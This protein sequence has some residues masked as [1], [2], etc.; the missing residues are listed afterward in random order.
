MHTS[1]DSQL[2]ERRLEWPESLVDCVIDTDTYNEI[3]DQF[4]LVHALLSPERLNVEAIYAAPFHNNRSNGPADGMEK[5]YEEIQRLL[6][7][8]GRS[9]SLAFRGSQ[10]WLR[11]GGD[12]ASSQARDDL[13]E[14]AL[15][16]ADDDPLYVI[17]IGA[18]TNIASA[19]AAEPR[20]RQKIVVIWLGGQPL[21]WQSANEFNL[22]GDAVASRYLLDSRVPLV[23]FPCSLVAE[24]LRTTL[25]ELEQHL[26]GRGAVADYLYGIFS[27]FEEIDLSKPG[28]SKVIWDLAP[29]AWLID[30]KMAA[31]SLTPSPILTDAFTWA[32]DP[33]R[34]PIRVADRIDRDR[35]F[36]DLFAKVDAVEELGAQ[37]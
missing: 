21:C 29:V 34:H 13:V 8:L 18:I 31:T 17:A 19:I 2:L 23:L 36:A 16:R 5:S 4:A 9:D 20:I 11:K 35:V 28:A 27:R 33:E 1:L 12:S 6:A 32:T 25:P 15:R 24:S 30:R 3:D 37:M 22:A 10:R 14:R 26:R 7:M